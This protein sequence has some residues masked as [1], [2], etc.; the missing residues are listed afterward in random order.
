MGFSIRVMPGVRV[1]ASSRGVRTSIGPRIAR[2]HVGAGSV[3]FSTGF[4]PIGYSQSM[5]TGPSRRSAI[6]AATAWMETPRSELP[7][8]LQEAIAIKEGMDAI[9]NLH[10]LPVPASR[11]N[12]G[13]DDERALVQLAAA[14][15]LEGA[16]AVPVGVFER[17]AS[18]VVR[19]PHVSKMPSKT[20]D[21]HRGSNLLLRPF[22]ADE[23]AAFYNVLVTG[24]ILLTARQAFAAC[25]SLT[26]TRVVGIREASDGVEVVM[27]ALLAREPVMNAKIKTLL[28][29]A[30]LVGISEDLVFEYANADGLV[31]ALNLESHPDL[32]ALVRAVD[33]ESLSGDIRTS[34]R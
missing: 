1:S 28:P 19:I 25:P 6:G 10:R 31:G 8:T 12:Y 20:T 18:L 23:I 33:V 30:I 26:H 27:A 32:A 21:G 14:F 16:A 5:S 4:G 11:K 7:P 34:P 9:T 13:A 24:S 22:S 29:D 3:G 15:D 2:V 17:V